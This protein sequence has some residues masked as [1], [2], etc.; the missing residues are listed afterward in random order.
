MDL[1]GDAR[2]ALPLPVQF[3]SFSCSFRQKSCQT[4]M[5]S[6]G[7]RYD[8]CI[9]CH[10]MSVPSGWGLCLERDLCPEGGGLCPE[11]GSL[12]RGGFPTP[13]ADMQMLLKT[14]PSL[15]VG[16]NI[17]WPILRGQRLLW[18]ILDT[19]LELFFKRNL[20]VRVAVSIL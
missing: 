7:M 14:S 10:W 13:L 2:D 15:A 6:S 9:D 11:G 12:S 4:G 3:L 8:R 17:F 1:R 19:P 20:F 18:E 5:Y 16:N